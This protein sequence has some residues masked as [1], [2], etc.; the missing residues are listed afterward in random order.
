MKL[1]KKVVPIILAAMMAMPVMA[2]CA[3]E[4]E[5]YDF[6]IWCYQTDTSIR[7]YGE[8]P[9]FKELEK[10]TG[11]KV[12]FILGSDQ[13]NLIATKSYPEVCLWLGYNEGYSR[14][15]SDGVVKDITQL[16]K[17]NAPN[18]KKYL[19]SNEDYWL[20]ATTEDDNG[21]LQIGAFYVLCNQE[22][23][24]WRGYVMRKDF[25][26]ENKDKFSTY[27]DWEDLGEKDSSG[28]TLLTPVLYSHW[29]DIF[30]V[31]KKL[32]R[33]TNGAEGFKYPFSVNA[34]CYDV[35]DTL[36]AGFDLA[37]ANAWYEDETG[38]LRFGFIEEGFKDY[39]SLIHEWYEAGYITPNFAES[40]NSLTSSTTEILGT[41]KASP[42]AM[43]FPEIATYVDARIEKGQENGIEDYELMGV[44]NPRQTKDQTLHLYS[45]GGMT[46][47]SA[48]ITTKCSD[49]KAKEIVEWFDYL[50]TDEGIELMNYGVEGETYTKNA[51]GTINF[52]DE[53]KNSPDKGL[54]EYASY[55]FPTI[56]DITRNNMYKTQRALDII[57]IWKY[58]IDYTW[59]FSSATSFKASEG[60]EYSQIMTDATIYIS[61]CLPKFVRGTIPTSDFASYVQELKTKYN[62]DRAIE[63]RQAAH[64]AFAERVIP[65]DWKSE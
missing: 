40:S 23:D 50:Y 20:S 45:F 10:R 49:E 7:N 59:E 25:I 21:N 31:A 65:D 12:K 51:D 32:Y 62:V 39:Y 22:E 54:Y 58:K 52:C 27:S 53:I 14:A 55:N 30:S 4:E 37:L 61:E 26:E 60:L 19:A 1:F 33:D 41:K 46:G 48:A 36:T 6:T 16:V 5:D 2:S 3:K 8:S 18:Y 29:T 42:T 63:I 38:A 24:P 11:K 17:N 47:M 64:T 34:G 56:S 44:P 57:N 43:C 35:L 13:E 15:I 28:N 9:A